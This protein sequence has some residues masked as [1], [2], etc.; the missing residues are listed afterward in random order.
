MWIERLLQRIPKKSGISGK[1]TQGL[2][3]RSLNSNYLVVPMRKI[4]P[5]LVTLLLGAGYTPSSAQYYFLN[6]GYYENDWVI[7]AGG[8]FGVMNAMTDL[9]GKK[10]IGKPFLKDLNLQNTNLSGGFYF[11]GMYRS[12]IGIRLE[13]CF[14]SVEGAD[15]LLKAVK[16]STFGRYERNLSFR[17]KINE[18]QVGVEFHPLFLSSHIYDENG[19][20]LISPY[21]HAGI[22]FFAFDPKAQLNGQWYSLQPLHTEGQGFTQYRD[23]KPYKL[24]QR[25]YHLGTGIRME[26]TDFIVARLE[27][28]HRILNT[29]YL[30]DV[31]QDSYIDPS[32]FFQNL[33]PGRAAIASQIY[34]RGDELNPPDVF[35]TGK[36]RGNPRNKDSYFTMQLKVGILL[37]RQRR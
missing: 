12:L 8:S 23:R 36:Q 1:K 18:I 21:I 13:G 34:F 11:T 29:D 4:L 5:L 32:L 6:N 17:S 33:S 7:E 35:S 26:L 2:I 24:Q 10:G 19:P 31:S 30:D 25:N 37:G 15:S 3:R 16:T 9:G 22:G 28:D 20:P 27:V 14:G